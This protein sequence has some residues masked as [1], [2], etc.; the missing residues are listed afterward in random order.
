MIKFDPTV[1]KFLTLTSF[2]IYWSLFPSE[3]V[4]CTRWKKALVDSS[5]EFSPVHVVSKDISFT[6]QLLPAACSSKHDAR[7]CQAWVVPISTDSQSLVVLSMFFQEAKKKYWVWLRVC[8]SF[9]FSPPL[10]YSLRPWFNQ[11]ILIAF[12]QYLHA[13][14]SQ[15]QAGER[16]K[17]RERSTRSWNE[18][19]V[20]FDFTIGIRELQLISGTESRGIKWPETRSGNWLA[21]L[22]FHFVAS[23]LEVL[24]PLVCRTKGFKAFERTKEH[25]PDCVVGGLKKEYWKREREST[26]ASVLQNAS[27][28]RGRM[29]WRVG[30]QSEWE[31][32]TRHI[33]IVSSVISCFLLMRKTIPHS[34][35]LIFS[36]YKIRFSLSLSLC[37]CAAPLIILALSFFHPRSGLWSLWCFNSAAAS[38]VVSKRE[39]E[40]WLEKKR[41]RK[42]GRRGEENEG[43]KNE[44]SG[45]EKGDDESSWVQSWLCVLL[46]LHNHRKQRLPSNTH[47]HSVQWLNCMFRGIL[48]VRWSP[49]QHMSYALFS[50]PF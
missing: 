31:E 32:H 43:M 36:G 46:M 42:T 18:V 50:R 20:C 16:N 30:T 1:C 45:W 34:A 4:W 44:K 39:R 49:R 37:T 47:T 41:G 35:F 17:W 33:H 38:V 25:L 9:L 11:Y 13:R 6:R 3:H 5:L 8:C 29:E 12:G 24:L 21:F 7:I 27:K 23:L 15:S 40:K 10:L 22:P 48:Y 19:S 28:K 2:A 26:H 14:G